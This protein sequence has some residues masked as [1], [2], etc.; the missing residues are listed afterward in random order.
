LNVV[1]GEVDHKVPL[2]K[3]G[4]EADWNLGWICKAPC[5]E[6]KTMLESSGGKRKRKRGCEVNGN[7]IGGW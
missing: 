4:S 3:G 7:P 5:H 2:C 1:D 6:D